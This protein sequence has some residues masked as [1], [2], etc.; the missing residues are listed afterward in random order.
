M[1]L[2]RFLEVSPNVLSIINTYG[3]FVVMSTDDTKKNQHIRKQQLWENTTQSSV[4][5]D[6]SGN[7][8]KQDGRQGGLPY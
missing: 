3:P 2:K 7:P 8:N 1:T 4:C 6:Q 5:L